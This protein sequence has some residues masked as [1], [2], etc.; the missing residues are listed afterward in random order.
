MLFSKYCFS[1]LVVGVLLYLAYFIMLSQ[2]LI[3]ILY[4]GKSEIFTTKLRHFVSP[5]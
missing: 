3:T 5:S 1:A 4:L 2:S